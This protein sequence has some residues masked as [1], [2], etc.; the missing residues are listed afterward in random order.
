MGGALVAVQPLLL[1]ALLT[2]GVDHRGDLLPD[3]A[4][5]GGVQ[6][7]RLLQQD[8]LGLGAQRLV[9]GQRV[10]GVHD[11]R[12]LL[13]RHHP[14]GQGVVGGGALPDQHR[15]LAHRAVTHRA[16]LPRGVGEPVGGR[17]PRQ[18]VLG[19]LAVRDLGDDGGLDRGQVGAQPLDLPVDRHQLL[20]SPGGPQLLIDPLD[21]RVGS[22][23]HTR[24]PA[25]H[26]TGR[27]GTGRHG[28]GRRG[29]GLL[30]DPTQ[31]EGTDTPTPPGGVPHR[32]QVT[33]RQR[34]RVASPG[35]PRG[36]ARRRVHV[37]SCTPERVLTGRDQQPLSRP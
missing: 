13:R 6:P 16:L 4:Q 25:R 33:K 5:L 12:R 17:T 27:H 2:V 22:R 15:R 3:H 9:E 26:G 10:H 1:A 7:G 19:D 35:P 24:R 23:D 28:T 18:L 29:G 36:A 14:A 37:R 30:H 34:F 8:S 32:P 11:H 20:R 31:P 21:Q